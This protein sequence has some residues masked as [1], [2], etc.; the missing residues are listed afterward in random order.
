[1]GGKDRIEMSQWDLQRWHVIKKAIGKEIRQWQAAEVL[2]VSQRHIRRLVKRVRQAGEA[3]VLHASRGKASNHQIDLKLKEKV[4]KLYERKYAD[5]GPTLASE[6]LE[7]LEGVRVLDETLR[8]W[9]IEKQIEYK[10]RRKRPH[11]N[12]RPRKASFG[13]MI[14]IDGSHHAWLEGRAPKL[15][16]MGYKDDAT[17]EVY[18]R[19]YQYEGTFPAMDSFKRYIKRYGI[20]QS[21]YLDKHTTYKG[22]K[23]NLSDEELLNNCKPKSQ[24]ERALS[25][26]GVQV[27]HA[28]SPQAKGRIERQ[29]RTFQ[30]RLVRELRLAGATTLQDA[31]EVLTRYLRGYNKRFNVAAANSQDLH[32]PVPKELNLKRI[33]CLKEDRFLRNDHTVHYAGKLYQILN[34]LTAK[35][36]TAEENLDGSI[37]FSHNG[38]ALNFRLT[39]PLPKQASK[40]KLPT[41]ISMKRT[42]GQNHPWKTHREPSMTLT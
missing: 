4:L 7:E 11:R 5:F 3:G 21:V 12:W 15:V 9:L 31:N 24:F 34:R 10:G 1:M 18:G 37:L 32:R 28:H 39:A 29:F 8:L 30:H 25:E 16:L 13:E 14:Q 19:F 35:K 6:K 22:W 17:G 33:F 2:G 42:P 40:P 26:L 23:K 36:V 38:T 41:W 27:I 20:P